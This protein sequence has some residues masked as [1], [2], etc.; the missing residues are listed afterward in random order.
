MGDK[1]F[2]V[3]NRFG[4]ADIAAGSLLGYVDVRFKEY[5]WRTTHPNL[6]KYYDALAERQSFKDTVPYPQTIKDKIV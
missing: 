4:L 5:P 2:I 1:E 6:A 3:G